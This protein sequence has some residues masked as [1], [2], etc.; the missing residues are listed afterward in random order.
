MVEPTALNQPS[1][2]DFTTPILATGTSASAPGDSKSSG[3][4]TVA[5]L[6]TTRASV[7]ELTL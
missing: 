6:C 3:E 5:S 4:V 7:G 1:A 2:A